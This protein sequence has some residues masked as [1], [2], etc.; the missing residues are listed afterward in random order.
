MHAYLDAKIQYETL[1]ADRT[2]QVEDEVL[3]SFY[4]S[5]LALPCMT[6]EADPNAPVTVADAALLLS[7]MSLDEARALR[8]G[9]ATGFQV[10][11]DVKKAEPS[12]NDRTLLLSLL[13]DAALTDCYEITLT[14]TLSDNSKVLSSSAVTEM[15]LPLTLHFPLPSSA[16]VSEGYRRSYYAASIHNAGSEKQTLSLLSDSSKDGKKIVIECSR[17]SLFG[18]LQK[19]IKNTSG[20]S[21]GGQGSSGGSSGNSSGGSSSNSSGNSSGGSSGSSQ[22]GSSTYVPDYEKDFWDNVASLIRKAKSGETVNVNAVTYDRMPEDVMAALRENPAVALIIRWDGGEPVI[23]PAQ[24]ALAKEAGRVYYPLS[25][26]SELYQAVNASLLG[27]AAAGSGQTAGS[28]S[29]SSSVEISAPSGNGSYTPTSKDMGTETSE[30]SEEQTSE[31]ASENAST[32][33][34]AE[35][36]SEPA[37]NTPALD[38]VT[39]E[40][41]QKQDDGMTSLILVI[42]ALLLVAVIVVLIV[43]LSVRKGGRA[44]SEDEPEFSGDESEIAEDAPESSWISEDYEMDEE[45][46]LDDQ[47]DDR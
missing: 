9:S 33:P 30:S 32:Q 2:L 17:F 34:A 10:T 16:A 1:S 12:E 3:S 22:N 41:T 44:R 46:F 42:A 37:Q 21:G 14:K 27:Q 19:D 5:F 7:S 4:H 13:K 28:G 25:L 23:I 43:L 15:P 6:V 36:P 11:M 38:L 35:A 18:I 40:I 39:K 45:D 8:D 47:T 24:T 31:A 29:G 26:L 20:S